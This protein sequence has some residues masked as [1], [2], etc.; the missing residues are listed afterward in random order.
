MNS[1]SIATGIA[2]HAK[3][4]ETQVDWHI[5]SKPP[6]Y[7]VEATYDNKILHEDVENDADIQFFFTKLIY[8]INGLLD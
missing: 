4:G 5:V 8:E 3:T 6:V 7:E 2:F 1:L